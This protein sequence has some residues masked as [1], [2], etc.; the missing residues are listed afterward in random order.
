MGFNT[1]YA[2]DI[3]LITITKLGER[4]DA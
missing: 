4:C 1:T 3:S 2:W